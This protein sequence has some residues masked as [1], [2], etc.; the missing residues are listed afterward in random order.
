ML[1]SEA[2]ERKDRHEKLIEALRDKHKTIV[3]SRDDEITELKIKLSDS[4]DLKESLR[5]EN[6][7]LQKEINKML[8]Q[9]KNFREESE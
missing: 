8:E 7:S 6:E 1:Q 2:K 4:L 3:E 5:V 9:W